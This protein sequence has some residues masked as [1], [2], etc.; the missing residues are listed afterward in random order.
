MSRLIRSDGK[1]D[2]NGIYDIFEELGATYKYVDYSE[3]YKEIPKPLED[4]QMVT[5][6]NFMY[7]KLFTNIHGSRII[8]VNQFIPIPY[9]WIF[10]LFC[11]ENSYMVTRL[12][13]NN[14]QIIFSLRDTT[15][16]VRMLS[17]DAE[18]HFM[19]NI[20]NNVD[21]GFCD[22]EIISNN[23][24]H[25]LP[26]P[27]GASSYNADPLAKRWLTLIQPVI[28]TEYIGMYKL[29]NIL[30]HQY[31]IEKL[32]D[33]PVVLNLTIVTD[34][35][36]SYYRR[37]ITIKTSKPLH[38]HQVHG[39]NVSVRFSVKESRFKIIPN[40]ILEDESVFDDNHI[41]R[42]DNITICGIN[43]IYRYIDAIFK[44]K[45]GTIEQQEELLRHFNAKT[46]ED[47]IMFLNQI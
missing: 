24:E 21:R 11:L 6:N 29:Q 37:G 41:P 34:I 32:I 17:D 43:H 35:P 25:I 18:T 19:F 46:Y 26:L 27:A 33:I 36:V 42:L 23:L 28:M 14:L 20:N 38:E 13:L 45:V 40:S 39:L 10:Y 7:K 44:F 9:E 47:I 2:L 30:E 4:G 12:Y 1:V 5:C 16:W 3:G 8:N 15:C 22:T 31:N